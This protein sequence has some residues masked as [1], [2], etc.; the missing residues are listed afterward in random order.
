MERV[1]K[2]AKMYYQLGY[3]QK[4]I[5]AQL[6]VSRP[7]VSRLLQEAKDKG[8]VQ[9]RIIDTIEDEQKYA[10]Q[11]K[12]RFGLK[13]CI[14]VNV[15]TND[16]NVI[17]KY[18]GPKAAD[19]LYKTVTDGDIIGLSWGTT[20]YEVAK[21]M[22]KKHVHHVDVVQL[23]GGISHSQSNTY[24]AEILNYFGAAYNTSPY[25][26]PLPAIV[27]REDMKEIIVA[28]R[29]I[30][31][32]LELGQKSN[33]AL[34]T[35]GDKHEDSTLIKAGYFNTNDLEVLEEKQAVGDIC[36]RFFN[37]Q[38]ELCSADLNAR[39]IGIN[40]D[41]LAKKEAS[42]L[43]AGGSRKLDSITGA[44]H[45]RFANVFI[46]DQYTAEALVKNS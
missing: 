19:Y 45:G 9:I 2:A 31:N 7:S 4:E 15:P 16:E 17:K 44:L 28:D 42:I 13:E 32:V 14:V 23:N 30:S 36:S 40:L 39:T 8:I 27:E 1:I 21:N 24:A 34:F 35:V 37:L 18:L 46:T 43:I 41:L 25:F 10:E 29:H 20:L 26:L 3:S 33:I 22:A 5:A 12:H 11:L 6:G 38:G